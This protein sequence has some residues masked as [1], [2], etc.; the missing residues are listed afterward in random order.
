MFSKTALSSKIAILALLILAG[1]FGNLK[2][3]QWQSQKQIEQE[4]QKLQSQAEALQKKNDELNLSLSYLNSPDFKER[5]ARQ[6][7]NLKKQGETVYT[8]GDLPGN[9]G[10]DEAE[11]KNGN[12]KKWRDHFFGTE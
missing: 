7:L 11:Q 5:V 10:L 4:K 6:Q 3:K 2:F 1:F 12:A 9:A 8:F